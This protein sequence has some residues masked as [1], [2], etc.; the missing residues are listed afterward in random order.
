MKSAIPKSFSSPKKNPSLNKLRN[1]LKVLEARRRNLVILRGATSSN[2][3]SRKSYPYQPPN[4]TAS[5]PI[6][7]IR[8]ALMVPNGS[9]ME[10]PGLKI[11]DFPVAPTIEIKMS[12]QPGTHI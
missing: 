1:H 3:I 8:L 6:Q 9:P 12:H 7:L 5:A 10:I 4:N 2:R 11:L